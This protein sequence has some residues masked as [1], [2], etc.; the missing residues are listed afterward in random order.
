MRTG[1]STS[2]LRVA[3]GTDALAAASVQV[4]ESYEVR[5]LA[6]ADASDADRVAQVVVTVLD[7]EK[8]G[9]TVVLSQSRWPSL[10]EA[11]LK[12]DEAWRPSLSGWQRAYSPALGRELAWGCAL[13]SKGAVPPGWDRADATGAHAHDGPIE[14][15]PALPGAHDAAVRLAGRGSARWGRHGRVLRSR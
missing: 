11:V 8:T 7:R 15:I 3:A 6:L 9:R 13:V 5:A 4:G 2:T 10:A 12:D 14:R 1:E